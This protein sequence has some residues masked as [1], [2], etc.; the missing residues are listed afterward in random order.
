MA[1]AKFWLAQFE[2]KANWPLTWR[3]IADDL[4]AGA[5]WLA[6]EHRKWNPM[7][8]RATKTM[9]RRAQLLRP[10]LLLRA[11]GLEALLKG[12]AVRRG[13]RFVVNG[14]FHP[15]PG[16]G[17]GHD[18]ILLADTTSFPLSASERDVLSRLSPQL[19]LARYPIAKSWNA[20]LKK[21]PKPGIG[22]V[23][24]THYSGADDRVV[25]RLAKR[26]RCSLR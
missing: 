12:R 20:G 9:P 21:H 3:M 11:A 19:E 4:F 5:D 18:L 1:D 10:M 16:T 7:T 17:K 14:A 13:H 15:I 26:H 23:L 24:A 22:H 8:S 6:A 2:R 25:A